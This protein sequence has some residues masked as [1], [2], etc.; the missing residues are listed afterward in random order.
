MFTDVSH[1]AFCYSFSIHHQRETLSKV[2]WHGKEVGRRYGW[3]TFRYPQWDFQR[4]FLSL[5]TGEFWFEL[6]DLF[7]IVLIPSNLGLLVFSYVNLPGEKSTPFT[8][9]YIQFTISYYQTHSRLLCCVF[10][11]SSIFNTFPTGYMR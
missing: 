3:D 8:T 9:Y 6:T 11:C 5:V 7:N 2:S 10:P 4:T 1:E